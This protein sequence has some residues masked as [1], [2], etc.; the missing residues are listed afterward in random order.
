M[1]SLY[2]LLL[3][4]LLHLVVGIL[5]LLVDI[6]ND[7]SLVRSRLVVWLG[8]NVSDILVWLVEVGIWL[9]TSIGHCNVVLL[10]IVLNNVCLWLLHR[11]RKSVF[12]VVPFCSHIS[13]HSVWICLQLIQSF[14]FL[15]IH[16]ETDSISHKK[17]VVGY[18]QEPAHQVVVALGVLIVVVTWVLPG[19]L[20]VLEIINYP[21]EIVEAQE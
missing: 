3:V 6:H 18:D 19:V 14:D 8:I 4:R 17:T 7:H 15:N 11:L 1:I 5:R 13:I 2:L 9:H 21:N 10:R 16:E 20:S 12:I